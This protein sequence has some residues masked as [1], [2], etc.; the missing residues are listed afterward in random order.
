MT[1]RGESLSSRRLQPFTGRLSLFS[2]VDLLPPHLRPPRC[3]QKSFLLGALAT[4]SYMSVP[5][6][7]KDWS[8]SKNCLGR[9][10]RLQTTRGGPRISLD[11]SALLSEATLNSD[12]WNHLRGN[13]GKPS[14]NPTL[15][16]MCTA[17]VV[18]DGYVCGMCVLGVGVR[19]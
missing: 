16:R 4:R 19:L 5:L 11:Q 10:K 14:K 15:V 17:P 1:R 3:W 6:P 7:C 8:F 12:S 18:P 9:Q 2:R 13:P